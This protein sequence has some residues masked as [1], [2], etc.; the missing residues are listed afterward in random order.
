VV[1]G[2]EFAAARKYAIEPDGVPC[3][4]VTRPAVAL[5]DVVGVGARTVAARARECDHVGTLAHG[6]AKWLGSVLSQLLA[7][8]MGFTRA[9]TSL[10][11][12]LIRRLAW[13][14]V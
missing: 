14:T 12:I 5:A 8:G 3:P 1:A 13:P 4:V 11:L 2:A 9:S 10:T 7:L 6:V